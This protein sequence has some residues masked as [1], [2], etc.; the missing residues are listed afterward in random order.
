MWSYSEIKAERV[1]SSM[2][3]TLK[4]S[5]AKMAPPRNFLAQT[6]LKALFYSRASILDYEPFLVENG[7]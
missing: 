5:A 1:I 7:I 4:K 2:Y 6:L 3:V